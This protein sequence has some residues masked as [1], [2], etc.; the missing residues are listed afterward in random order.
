MYLAIIRRRRSEHRVNNRRDDVEANIHQCSLSLRRIIVLVRI[1]FR[2]EYQ[3]PQENGLKHKKD[4]IV[5]VHA[6]MQP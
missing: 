1:I 5:H 2:V 6:R 3:E 4:A